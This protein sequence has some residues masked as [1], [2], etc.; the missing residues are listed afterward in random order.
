MRVITLLT[1]GVATNFLD[2]QPAPPLPENSYYQGIRD[3]IEHQPEHISFSVSPES[4]ANDVVLQV[5]KGTTGKYWIG[6]G[7]GIARSALW[8]LPQSAIVGFL[9][10]RYA[11]N[12]SRFAND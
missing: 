9:L 12:R 6:G 4:Y 1:G 7:S 10:L 8:L 3:I 5:E 2:N 11:T